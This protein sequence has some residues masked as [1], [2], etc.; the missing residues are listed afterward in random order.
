MLCF[1]QNERQMPAAAPL[2]ALSLTQQ[3][4]GLGARIRAARKQQGVSASTAA[5]AAGMSR[6]T[7]HRI[8]AG[9]PSVTLGAFLSAAAAVGLQPLLQEAQ[10]PAAAPRAIRLGDYPG[11]RALALAA[12]R[13]HRAEPGTAAR[14]AR[15][16]GPPSRREPIARCRAGA[17]RRTAPARCLSAPT[18]AAWP[19]PCRRWMAT[20]SPRTPAGL[21][22]ARRWRCAL[23]STASRSTSTC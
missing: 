13:R 15:P 20:C 9:E 5:Q 17:A 16:P 18:T 11:L 12:Q 4:A 3:A 23:A 10:A 7:W 8:E 1:V 14:T 6:S 22:A 21:A 19:R 2:L